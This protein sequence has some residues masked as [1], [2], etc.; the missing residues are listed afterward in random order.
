MPDEHDREIRFSH[1]V[2]PARPLQQEPLSAG[3]VTRKILRA[4]NA[5]Q[6]R[7]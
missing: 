4:E 5:L 2:L 1:S 7:V 6:Q 3:P